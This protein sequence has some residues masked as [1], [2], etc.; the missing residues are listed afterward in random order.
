[1]T[2]D[3]TAERRI[4]RARADV[5]AF[6]MDPA[7]DRRWIGALTDVRV[8]TDGPVA[9]GTRVQRTARFLRRDM[10]YVNELVA[11]EPPDRLEMRSVEG[12]FAMRVVYEFGERG[13]GTTLTRIR[14]S[15]EGSRFYGLADPL[16][17][18]MVRRGITRD[19]R[20]LRRELE[21]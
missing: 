16:L 9:V 2:V 7:N 5:A 13:D 18:L 1:M 19:L 21:A 17:S 12:P 8:L 6:A 20:A 15:G 4:S 11:Y 10:V 3:V 14:A